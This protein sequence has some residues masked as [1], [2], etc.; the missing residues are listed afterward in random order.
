M[1]VQAS[2][3]KT[4]RKLIIIDPVAE[5]RQLALSFGAGVVIDPVNEDAADVVRHFTDGYG[6]DVYIEAAGAP[7]GVSRPCPGRPR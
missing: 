2:H 3:L 1:M 5:R 7:I 4:P 6:C